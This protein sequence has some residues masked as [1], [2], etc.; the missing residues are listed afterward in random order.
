MVPVLFYTHCKYLIIYLFIQTRMQSEFSCGITNEGCCHF[1][2]R[3]MRFKDYSYS[4]THL[5]VC[6]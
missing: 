5:C 4:Y 6:I 3:C 1:C 2:V